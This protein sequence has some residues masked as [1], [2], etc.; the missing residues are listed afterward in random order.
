MFQAPIYGGGQREINAATIYSN[1]WKLIIYFFLLSGVLIYQVT[2]LLF[3]KCHISNS[4]E[5]KTVNGFYSIRGF[6]LQLLKQQ[7]L[8][9]NY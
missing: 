9:L 4:T 5:I 2:S 6:F 7:R 1:N 3:I 8:D